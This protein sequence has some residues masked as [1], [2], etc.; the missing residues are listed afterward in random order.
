MFVSHRHMLEWTPADMLS[1]AR[2]D[3]PSFY[4]RMAG[5]VVLTVLIT[6]GLAAVSGGSLPVIAVPFVFLW[7][8]APLLAWRVSRTPPAVAKSA[9]SSVQQREL[10][11][12]ARRTWRYFETFV[13]AEDN[14]LPPDNFQ[15]DPRGVVAH[16]TSPTNI[17]LYLL[18]T[19]AARDFG[20]CG[21][22][23]A[24]DRIEPRSA[25]CACTSAAGISNWYDA[26]SRPLDP[27]YTSLG[28]L[29]Q[30]RGASHPTCRRF[31]E[32]QKAP[33]AGIRRRRSRRRPRP[34]A[35]GAAQFPVSAGAD[36]HT[37]PPGNR[38]LRFRNEPASAND[39]ARSKHRRAARC[40]RTRRDAG[41][42]GAHA[43]E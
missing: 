3:L 29:G 27:R 35:R 39:A 30:S 1:S 36:D 25:W 22:R 42:H 10:R 18:S 34:G 33:R 15:E 21:L 38:V 14:H 12:I 7:F 28:G 26:R 19:V 17:G 8:A 9:L 41:R 5:S 13:T 24:L 43:G 37:R 2:S 23:D 31:R 11:L 20:W 4:R 32:W 16:R 6:V 40:R